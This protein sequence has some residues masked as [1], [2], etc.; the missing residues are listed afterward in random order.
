MGPHHP[1]MS[2][3]KSEFPKMPTPFLDFF[4]LL[5]L[6]SLISPVTPFAL[7]SLPSYIIS[8]LPYSFISSQRKSKFEK[9]ILL[10]RKNV[11]EIRSS[12]PLK[13]IYILVPFPFT[14]LVSCNKFSNSK[15][16]LDSIIA[17]TKRCENL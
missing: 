7:S 2:F 17:K 16:F 3:L 9:T 11:H 14:P 4:S 8:S 5:S 1:L 15:F 6:F 13:N 10:K 12:H